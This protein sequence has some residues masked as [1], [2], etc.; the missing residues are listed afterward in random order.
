[1]KITE[2]QKKTFEK[3][4]SHIN[5][6]KIKA[7]S[8][9]ISDTLTEMPFLYN[10]DLFFLMEDE[11]SKISNGKKNFS[12][13]R[14]QAEK[15]AVK[16]DKFSEPNINAI[17]SEFS[18]LAGISSENSEKLMN[19]ESELIVKFTCPRKCGIELMREAERLNK[20]IVLTENTY[21]TEEIIEKILKKCGITGYRMIFLSDKTGLS[22]QNGDIYQHVLKRLKLNSGQLLHIG[23]NVQADLEAPINQGITAL[24]LPACREQ[25]FKN[26]KL[27]GYIYS[28][29]GKKINTQ[30]YFTL[31]C[32]MGMYALYTFDYPFSE[33]PEGDF[34]M[35]PENIG[36]AV[37]GG[38]SLYK[39]FS[40][41]K[42]L[43]TDVINAMRMDSE[44]LSGEC[45]FKKMYSECFGNT[46]E[47]LDSECCTLPF[48][49]FFSHACDT[50]RDFIRKNLSDSV[51]NEWCGNISEFDISE[52]IRK[53][54]TQKEKNSFLS[55]FIR[56]K[57]KK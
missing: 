41:E 3:L 21:L 19:L 10:T 42:K 20:K 43:M 2:N 15:N 44:I 35:C 5:Q 39:S 49:M 7:V 33:I 28:K 51:Y 14:V 18:E 30:K 17:Y 26:G 29:T 37:L 36:F 9:S 34:C 57:R 50:E 31:R 40:P 25:L 1:M 23:S 53:N 54:K 47:K 4:A 52:N 48:E 46:L 6:N 22:K 55:K 32:L 13:L 11:F 56:R 12:A 38:I 24:Y 45:D 27:C 16:N 8:F